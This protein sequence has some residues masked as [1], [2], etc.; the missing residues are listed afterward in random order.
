MEKKNCNGNSM[1]NIKIY[2]AVASILA[3][4]LTVSVMLSFELFDLE[5]R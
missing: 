5:K 4:A 3:L 2:K 1:A